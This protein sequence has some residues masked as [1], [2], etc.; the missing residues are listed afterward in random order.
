MNSLT[1]TIGLPG[2]GKT[3]WAMK[4]IAKM[5]AEGYECVA[6]SRDGI[7]HDLFDHV[8]EPGMPMPSPELEGQVT[9]Q[10]RIR[11]R[12]A[13]QRGHHVIVDDTN[14]REEYRLQFSYLARDE[15]ALFIQK[16]F[17]HVPVETCIENDLKRQAA[18]G[19]SVGADVIRM[20]AKRNGL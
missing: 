15:R 6:I 10:Q 7:R 4:Q 1:I 2:S 17:R 13:L 9:V 16:D 14:L 18:G 19:H 8:W 12:Q 3:Y 11:I 20:L 5:R